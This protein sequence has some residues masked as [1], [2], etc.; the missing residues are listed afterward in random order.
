[1]RLS[2]KANDLGAVLQPAFDDTQKAVAR[3]M[4]DVPAFA[5]RATIRSALKN[6]LRGLGIPRGT[7]DRVGSCRINGKRSVE[8]FYADAVLAKS[9]GTRA[10]WVDVAPLSHPLSHPIS[11]RTPQ[12]RVENGEIKWLVW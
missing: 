9:F 7:M 12:Y 5:S 6:A 2:F 3:A 10:G 8:V 11:H 1:M 4:D